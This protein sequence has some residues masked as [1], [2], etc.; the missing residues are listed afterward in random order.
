MQDGS[1]QQWPPNVVTWTSSDSSLATVD[2]GGV[3]RAI[4]PGAVSI[5]AVA[6]QATALQARSASCAVSGATAAGKQTTAQLGTYYF[7]GWA[8]PLTGYSFTGLLDGPYTDR[9]PLTGWLD[10]DPCVIEQQLAYARSFGINFFVFLWYKLGP[11]DVEDLNSAL[12]ITRSLP[13]RRGMK[14]AIM[15][16]NPNSLSLEEWASA[17]DD[18]VSYFTD[19]NY[20]KIDGKPLFMI[21]TPPY[22]RES[23]GG[24]AGVANAYRALRTAAQAKGL[25]GVY[26]VGGLLTAGY[27]GFP[28]HTGLGV[29]G[30]DALSMYNYPAAIKPPGP[31]PLPF[32]IL[33]EGGR[34][35]WAETARKTDSLFIPS[36]MDG[37]DARPWGDMELFYNRSPIEVASHVL[38]AIT[39]AENN[40][41]MRVEPSPTPPL[42]IIEA[43][44]ELG[45]GSY[46]LP[47]VGD[48]TAYGDAIVTMLMLPPAR[49]RTTLRIDET[50]ATSPTR[51]ATGN[52]KDTNGGAISGAPLTLYASPITGPGW[53]ST[54]SHS[55]TVPSGATT[56]EVR[57]HV[58]TETS[59]TAPSD[60]AVYRMSYKEGDGIER[61]TNGDFSAGMS[62]WTTYG[63]AELMSSDRGLGNMM[64]VQV[65]STET[66]RLDSATFTVTSGSP[67]TFSV[68]AR[69]A[70]IS[71]GSGYF[72]VLFYDAERVVIPL[73]AAR[74][75][76]GTTTTNANGDFALGLSSLGSD[77]VDLQVMFNGNSVFWPNYAHVAGR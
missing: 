51:T 42:V 20:L 62:G 13:N 77:P 10:S 29:E 50:G 40:P 76:V 26:I 37:W 41:R 63:H 31:G 16:A 45:E 4:S 46:M 17:V 32:S 61:V 71:L 58:N 56:A 14:Y 19:P 73:T 36:V 3:V 74:V 28:D 54:Y 2:P 44:N 53:Y 7:D 15:F 21:L 12:K 9:M 6:K 70:P 34:W 38:D 47:T 23:F 30:Y 49:Q 72:C 33:A 11:D 65:S 35:M 69:V 67:Y 57:F 5:T 68:A 27:L 18:W 60:F 24:S 55:G 43:W 8:G 1:T 52:L 39:W 25:P 59:T 75:Q 22:M 48:G 66:A 64:R